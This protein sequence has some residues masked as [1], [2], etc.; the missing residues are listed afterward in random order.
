M[1]I[2]PVVLQEF[3]R[4]VQRDLM[5]RIQELCIAWDQHF[6]DHCMA[7]TRVHPLYD[8]PKCIC[9][10]ALNNLT[11][12]LVWWTHWAKHSSTP[13]LL[14]SVDHVLFAHAHLSILFSFQICKLEGRSGP[15]NNNSSWSGLIMVLVWS[16]CLLPW[17]LPLTLI[18]HQK[19]GIIGFFGAFS[20]GHRM[21]HS[22]GRAVF[23]P[24]MPSFSVQLY[25]VLRK[26]DI[27]KACTCGWSPTPN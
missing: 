5:D 18:I 20:Q 9:P 19:Q 2:H 25:M 24:I 22:H 1:N 12:H 4:A 16:V 3:Y 10:L 14:I 15:W 13:L 21:R 27:D 17:N 8:R 11:I 23:H 26:R 7:Q 6:L